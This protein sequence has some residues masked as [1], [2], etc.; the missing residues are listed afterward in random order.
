MEQQKNKMIPKRFWKTHQPLK[1]HIQNYSST[2]YLSVSLP[3]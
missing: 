2:I 3:E 1:G